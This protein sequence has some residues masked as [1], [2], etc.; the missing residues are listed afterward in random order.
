MQVRD[1]L[2]AKGG[3]VISIEPEAKVSE[4]VARLVQNNIGSLPVVDGNGRLLGMFSER[5]VLRG[6]HNRGEGFGQIRVS[7]VMTPNPVTCGPDDEVDDVMGKMSERRIAK[8]PVVVDASLVGIVSVG[9][10]IKVMYDKV[11][12]ENQHL[13]TY[14]HGSY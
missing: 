7:D 9:D 11:H 12:S 4:A 6:L 5:D 3:R 13:L 14:I 2:K 8:V 1:V 10:V